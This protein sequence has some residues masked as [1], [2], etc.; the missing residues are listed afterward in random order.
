MAASG[1]VGF[2]R[3]LVVPLWN[4]LRFTIY[5]Y[6]SR[7]SIP[8]RFDIG[9]NSRA[10]VREK[11]TRRKCRTEALDRNLVILSARCS[12]RISSYSVKRYSY[13][14][15][16]YSYS[17]ERRGPYQSATTSE[18]YRI[19]KYLNGSSHRH[20]RHPCFEQR[21]RFLATLPK[22]MKSKA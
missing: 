17:K 10:R 8:K 22:A 14:V 20:A 1:A 9:E 19:A 15:K 4:A 21:S 12:A 3:S 13:S 16:R 5:C 18:S 6:R 2:S 7:R 11:R